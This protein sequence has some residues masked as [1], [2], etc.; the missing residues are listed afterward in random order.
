[1]TT[2][3]YLKLKDGTELP[4]GECG[5]AEHILWCFVKGL[6]MPE[7]FAVFSDPAKTGEITFYYG[8]TEDK[9]VGFTELN[10]VRKSEYT[11]DVQLTGGV[12]QERDEDVHD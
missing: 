11:I 12:R 6:T 10:V 7:V 2:R 8:T 9:Y 3:P 5:Y 4:G 1:M